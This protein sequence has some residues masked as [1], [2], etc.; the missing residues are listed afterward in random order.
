MIKT[1][2][3]VVVKVFRSDNG[4]EFVNNNLK[5]L[6]RKLG[7]VYQTSCVETSQQNEIVER[8]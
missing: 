2:F 7:I 1:Q 8:K 6:F 3:N 5:S 4:T